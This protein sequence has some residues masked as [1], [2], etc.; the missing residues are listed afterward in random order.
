MKKLM[1]L[2]TTLLAPALLAPSMASAAPM[3]LT[4]TAGNTL[5]QTHSSAVMF[6]ITGTFKD[7]NG[8]LTFDPVTKACN[9]EL[10]L[11]VKSMELPN[12]IVRAQVM[13]SSFLD[14]DT[15]PG[16]KY[17]GTCQGD[18]LVGNLTMHGQTHPFNLALTYV[19]KDGQLTGF[20][21]VGTLNRY[22]WGLNGLQMMVGKMIKVNNDIS[23]T[24]A[25]PVPPG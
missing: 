25:P 10:N 13:S 14:P 24:G 23:L 20:D 7:L 3:A 21:S 12:A 17:V 2:A 5:S 11:V 16:M 18:Q 6:T 4:L 8:T 15:Y 9:V 22:D 1:L 19:M